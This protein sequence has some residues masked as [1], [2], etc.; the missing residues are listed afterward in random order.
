VED[1]AFKVNKFFIGSEGILKLHRFSNKLIPFTLQ[2]N[3]G[4]VS[5]ITADHFLP[6]PSQFNID[7]HS[8]IHVTW[9]GLL[10]LS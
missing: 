10:T 3:A 7:C 1:K 2:A 8:V 9:T 5:E 4:L 6:N